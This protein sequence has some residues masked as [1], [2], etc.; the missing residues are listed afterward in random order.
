MRAFCHLAILL[1][2]VVGCSG[3]SS[4]SDPVDA[5]DILNTA[6]VAHGGTDALRAASTWK[7]EIRRHQRGSSYVM[8]N[9]YR[10]GMVRLEQDSGDGRR[11]A[12]VIGDPHCWGMAGVVS[13]PC[14]SETR[15]NDRPRVIMEMAVQMWPL[16][17]QPWELRSAST[18]EEAGRTLDIVEAF[19]APRNTLVELAFDGETHLLNSMSVSGIKRGVVGRHLHVYSDYV[20]RCGVKM[21]AHNIKSF[22]GEVWVAEDVLELQCIPVDESLFTRP[23]QVSDEFTLLMG[24]SDTLLVCVNQ[25]VPAETT[26]VSQDNLAGAVL[27]N[28]LAAVDDPGEYLFE[29]GMAKLCIPVQDI[30]DLAV[31]GLSTHQIVE[32]KALSIYALG[33]IDG[34]K[35]SIIQKLGAAAE[36]LGYELEWPIRM[37]TFDNDGMGLTGEVVVELSAPIGN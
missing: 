8:T 22:E 37:T 36:E 1:F 29:D 5:S 34:R 12:D 4:E 7:A 35:D 31:P 24:L 3:K 18:R 17:Q 32:G 25:A 9:Y 11:S 10:P 14:S 21:P 33:G 27:D 19:Y 26:Q 2:V 15:E 20:E 13:I 16:L 30:D 23:T 28:G 6:I